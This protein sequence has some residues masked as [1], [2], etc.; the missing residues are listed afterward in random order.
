MSNV[1]FDHL[2][3]RIELLVA[4][5]TER[6]RLRLFARLASPGLRPRAL[7]PD[8]ST[9]SSSFFCTGGVAGISEFGFSKL[10]TAAEA[11]EFGFSKLGWSLVT[12]L[13]VSPA[14]LAIEL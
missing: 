9:R 5:A 14:S 13:G 3:E 1:V 8:F 6:L 7:R 2:G 4:H 11:P 12:V 10:E